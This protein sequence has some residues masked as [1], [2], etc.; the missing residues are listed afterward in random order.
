[1]LIK[2]CGL[3]EE[4]N[5]NKVSLAD[6]DM[7]GLNFYPVSKR[8]LSNEI[9]TSKISKN[10]SMVGVFVN[11]SYQEIIKLVEKY[12]L[13]YIQLHGD[14]DNVFCKKLRE[15]VKV[16]KAISIKSSEDFHKA[17]AFTDVDYILFDTKTKMYG[18][19]GRKFDWSILDNY[20]GN[21]PFILAGGIKPDDVKAIKEINHKSF[22]GI[23]INS[24]F[25][26]EP[27]IKSVPEVYKFAYAIK[28]ES[29]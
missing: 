21:I 8:Y 15:Q 26:S 24:Q 11:E 5:L 1:M 18:G 28:N 14:E 12:N 29:Y 2:V 3:K 13:E 17:E 20:E 4:V 6:I 10:I 25:E 9:N 23:D 22:R 7:I 27:G 16:I 19:S